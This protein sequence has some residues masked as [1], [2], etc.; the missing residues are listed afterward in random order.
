[1]RESDTFLTN[2]VVVFV[3][4]QLASISSTE[5]PW[6]PKRAK[7][8]PQHTWSQPHSLVLSAAKVKRS[9]IWLLEPDSLGGNP[10]MAF[11]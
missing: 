10:N 4:Y 1:M 2:K 3:L 7:L 11:L 9:R 8:C 5:L 6:D